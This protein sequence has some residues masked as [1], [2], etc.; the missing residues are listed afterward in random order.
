YVYGLALQIRRMMAATDPKTMHKAVQISGALTDEAVRNRLI[1][2]V[3]KR[4]NVGNLARIK[5][6]RGN[7]G[8]QARGMAFMLG[9]VE[10]RQD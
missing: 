4:G 10:A 9:A 2:K 1:K 8:N 5:M 3:K 6:G 7:Q